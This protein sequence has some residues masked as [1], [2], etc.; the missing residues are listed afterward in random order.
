[1]YHHLRGVLLKNYLELFVTFFK[2]GVLSFGGGYAM[3]PVVERELINKRSWVSMDE[4]MDYYTVAQITPGIIAVNLS[5]F[6]GYKRKGPLGGVLATLGFVLPGV[7]F[8]TAIAVFLA[9]FADFPAVK[10]AFTGIRVAVCA[11]ILNTVIKLVKGVFKDK[12]AVG[13]YTAA[14]ALSVAL[15]LSPMLLIAASGL[16]GLLLFRPKPVQEN[17]DPPPD[18]PG[19]TGA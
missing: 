4:V 2:M 6:V 15:N 17:Q 16:L 12:K 18:T 9:N 13:I 1:M 14:F 10:H 5:T 19:G 7:S 8:V 11:L 3:I